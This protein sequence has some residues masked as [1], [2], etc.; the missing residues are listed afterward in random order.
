MGG[1]CL[2]EAAMNDRTGGDGVF[3]RASERNAEDYQTDGQNNALDHDWDTSL[4]FPHGRTLALCPAGL[5]C[6][7]QPAG[8]VAVKGSLLQMSLAAAL[9]AQSHLP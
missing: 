7:A 1:K 2:G 3:F 5:I 4:R 6:A 8:S 9:T